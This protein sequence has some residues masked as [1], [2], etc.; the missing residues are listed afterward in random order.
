M[1]Y[2]R[3]MKYKI[4][5]ALLILVVLFTLIQLPANQSGTTEQET[6]KEG[7]PDTVSIDKPTSI[8]NTG[9]VSTSTANIKSATTS[10]SLKL[11]TENLKPVLV[12]NEWVWIKTELG[13]RPIVDPN[14][15]VTPNKKGDFVLTFLDEGSISI[16]TDCNRMGGTYKFSE[17]KITF[18]SFMSTLMYCEGSKENEFAKMLQENKIYSLSFDNNNQNMFLTSDQTMYFEKK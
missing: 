1:E 5:L 13:T 10:A 6:I 18:G 3:D 4:T 14:L 16:K 2:N 7:V 9:Y 12:A 11:N 15:V 17:N 8:P